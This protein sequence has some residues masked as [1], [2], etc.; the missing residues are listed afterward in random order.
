[1]LSKKMHLIPQVIVDIAENLKNAKTENTKE[2]YRMRL[3]TIREF[4]DQVL[5]NDKHKGNRK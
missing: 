2:A 4:C 1:M 5:T 3:E